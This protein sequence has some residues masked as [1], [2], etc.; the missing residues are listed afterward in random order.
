MRRA[1]A[2]GDLAD[3]PLEQVLHL[4]REHVRAAGDLGRRGDD[5]DGPAGV[6]AG[7][8]D[9]RRLAAGRPRA[10]R[11]A[12]ARQTTG[13]RSRWGRPRSCGT[14]M[15]PPRPRISMRKTS[16]AARS[17]PGADRH[18]ADRQRRPQVQADHGVDAVHDACLDHPGGAAGQRLLAGLEQEADLAG[19]VL[20]HAGQHRGRAEQDR[21]VAVVPAGVHDAGVLRCER[22][23]GVLLDRQR[24]HVGADRER[25]PGRAADEAPDDAGARRARRPR[26]R[27]RRAAR[28]RSATSRSPG[29][30]SSGW[31][32][33]C[34]RHATT[35][36]V[37]SST[38]RSTVPSMT[39]V[40][41]RST[42]V[43]CKVSARQG[44][45]SMYGSAATTAAIAG[46]HETPY[47]RHPPDG[48]D[49]TGILAAAV[50]GALADAG[51]DHGAVDGLGV[52]SF[53]LVAR[54]RHR[55]GLAP[56]LRCAGSWTTPTAAPAR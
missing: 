37:T 56:G 25:G 16:H 12:A 46:A 47:A 50:A 27:G 33:R 20:A 40:S 15:W 29:R 31:A 10:R 1:D 41:L 18:G 43:T 45:V 28:R 9:D 54:P 19:E 5:P 11:C 7:D 22:Q 2:V 17:A 24:V 23:P 36:G 13:R 34:R 21:R 38:S 51:I 55:P 8:A 30:T 48:T 32:C 3:P 49:T 53:S 42:R 39:R 44:D 35:S 6:E 14:P 52:A 4:G 26:G